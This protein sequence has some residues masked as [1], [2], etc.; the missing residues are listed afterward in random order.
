M[1]VIEIPSAVT[2]QLLLIQK[3]SKNCQTMKQH[4]CCCHWHL[5]KI[6][7]CSCFN[8]IKEEKMEAHVCQP[9]HAQNHT[10]INKSRHKYMPHLSNHAGG[11]NIYLYGWVSLLAPLCCVCV[12]VFS[13]EC[14][15][16]YVWYQMKVPAFQPAKETKLQKEQ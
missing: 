14:L 15:C 9:M 11:V 4:I 5:I 1:K 12:C 6:H 3:N 10:D 7:F 2:K 16:L 8:S 13:F